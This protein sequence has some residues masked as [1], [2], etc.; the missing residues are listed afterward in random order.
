MHRETLVNLP[1]SL[2]RE[3]DSKI[4]YYILDGLGGSSAEGD[5]SLATILHD[6]ARRIKRRGLVILLSDCFDEVEPFL[7]ALYHLRARGHE[8]LLFHVMAPEEL[9]FSFT[10]HTRF[11]CLEREGVRMDLDPA[12][13][14]KKYLAS[15]E[16][17]L[18]RLRSGCNEVKCD[19]APLVTDQPI[20]EA[21][22]RH[23]A[24]RMARVK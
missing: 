21:L 2:V 17:F 14:R 18:E 20:G 22:G 12:G 5:T 1:D 4:L 3:S 7:R 23:L 15:V 9:S 10:R 11:E 13:I 8:A 16:T 19:Y 6:L 24:L